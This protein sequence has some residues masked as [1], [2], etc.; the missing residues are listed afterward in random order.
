M[1]ELRRFP[2]LDALSH[3]VAGEL[4]VLAR[5]SVTARGVCHIA[6]SGGSTP[7]R[8]F[9]IVRELRMPWPQIE[10]WFG[11][12]RTVPPEHADS[13]YRMAHE[14]LIAPLGLSRVHRM[15]G[16]DDPTAAAAAYEREI[17]HR[18]DLVLLR[19]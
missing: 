8:L 4:V 19:H 15:H 6:L 3:A 1:A 5:D 11:D 7:R 10:L 2:D 12:E 16:E 18:D 17:V 13:N 14:T 9:Q